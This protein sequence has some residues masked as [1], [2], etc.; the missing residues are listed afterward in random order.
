MSSVIDLTSSASM[1]ADSAA[2]EI[3][4]FGGPVDALGATA[5]LDLVDQLDAT[6]V[7]QDFDVVGD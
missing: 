2:R 1:N 6:E 7:A 5:V 3:V 4:P